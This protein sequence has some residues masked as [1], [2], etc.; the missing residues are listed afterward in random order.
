MKDITEI[1]KTYR[2]ALENTLNR[3]QAESDGLKAVLGTISTD[4][5]PYFEGD[6]DGAL[7]LMDDMTGIETVI[8]NISNQISRVEEE[9]E[10]RLSGVTA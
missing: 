5:A 1:R 3:L 6:I 9:I 2:T 8:G 10:F 4:A 7:V